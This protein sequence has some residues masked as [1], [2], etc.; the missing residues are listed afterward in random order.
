MTSENPSNTPTPP[1][2]QAHEDTD[3]QATNP[4]SALLPTLRPEVQIPPSHSDYKI[5]CNKK[6]DGWDRAKMAAEFLG[7]LFLIIYTLY[8]RGIY[9][10]NQSAAKA[11]QDTLG[12]IKKQF[13][14]IQKSANAAQAANVISREALES[15]QRAF[16]SFPP[17]PQMNPVNFTSGR[18][19]RVSIEIDNVGNTQAHAVKDRVSWIAT[20][21][22]LPDNYS[23]PDRTGKWGLPFAATGA[24][25]IPAKGY[26]MSQEVSIDE[27]TLVQLSKTFPIL[28]NPVTHPHMSGVIFYGWVTYRDIFPDTPEHLTEFCRGLSFFLAQGGKGS[29]SWDFC[30]V[31]N[32][33]D[34]DCPD[35]QERITKA[36]AAPTFNS[37]AP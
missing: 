4:Q 26:V 3:N 22:P 30:P 10:A 13:P 2:N 6:R 25:V 11:A 31:H 16:V 33:T 15:V 32:C 27:Q 34:E 8:T 1:A 12:E 23:F 20:E 18:V 7:I 5:T 19:Y 28:P 37:K 35:Y 36:R 29:V 24:N 21:K 17:S 14:E 9:R